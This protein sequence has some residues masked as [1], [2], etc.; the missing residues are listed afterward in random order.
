RDKGARQVTVRVYL[1]NRTKA[2]M[3]AMYKGQPMPALATLTN[4]FKTPP[5]IVEPSQMYDL[6]SLRMDGIVPGKWKRGVSSYSN[7]S[8]YTGQQST[9]IGYLK[10]ANPGLEMK[11]TYIDLPAYGRDPWYS[12]LYNSSS[13]YDFQ[14]GTGYGHA[15]EDRIPLNKVYY[16]LG[17]RG[18]GGSSWETFRNGPFRKTHTRAGASSEGNGTYAPTDYA[19]DP[20]TTAH[21]STSYRPIADQFNH[22]MRY[23]E[24]WEKLNTG[25]PKT[26]RWLLDSMLEKRKRN[27]II[28][29]MHGEVFPM[30][31]MRNYSDPAKVPYDSVTSRV[32]S[33]WGVVPASSDDAKE[34]AKARLVTH[35]HKLEYGLADQVQLRVYPYVSDNREKKPEDDE[36]PSAYRRGIIVLRGVANNL[37]EAVSGEDP[38]HQIQIQVMEFHKKDYKHLLTGDC[39]ERIYRRELV[40]PPSHPAH[41]AGVQGKYIESVTTMTTAA[42]GYQAGDVVIKLKNIPYVHEQYRNQHQAPDCWLNKKDQRYGLRDDTHLYGLHYFPDPALPLLDQHRSDSDKE[43]PRNTARIFVTFKLKQPQ[44]VEVQTTIGGEDDLRKHKLPNLSR[45]WAWVGD[46]APE[47][48]RYQFLGDPRHNPYADV[49]ADKRYNRHFAQLTTDAYDVS[50][51]ASWNRFDDTTNGWGGD[52]TA[53]RHEAD[54][55]AYLGL[56]R[57]ALMR[58]NSMFAQGTGNGFNIIALGGEYGGDTWQAR[59][60]HSSKPFDGKT[61]LKDF[62]TWKRP[63][64]VVDEDNDDDKWFSIPWLGE[65]WPMENWEDWRDTGNLPSKDFRHREWKDVKGY[66]G[67]IPDYDHSRYVDHWGPLGFF[68]ADTDFGYKEDWRI[69]EPTS[70]NG[71][72]LDANLNAKLNP[73]LDVLYGYSLNE[74]VSSRPPDDDRF[75]RAKLQPG[76]KHGSPEYYKSSDGRAAIMPFLLRGSGAD[77]AYYL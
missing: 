27:V 1:S 23:V 11:R 49:R 4:I 42:N 45:T 50:S 48:E 18:G 20:L 71:K 34:G 12:P 58:S 40:W 13:T 74:S 5:V 41:K 51:G 36:P 47:S 44:R 10:G 22:A 76:L 52:K 7:P 6:Y 57:E 14:D 19:V 25:S 8:W 43:D 38:E 32:A 60:D 16:L 56:W 29:N 73:G 75:T 64:V 77:V 37:V 55:P 9:A 68:Y 31:P 24:E 70:D 15:D 66:D 54:V 33:N 26:L 39:D 46:P 2:A 63:T 17:N 28:S 35:P 61:D 3:R 67:H 30:I 72:A 65:I 21:T 62:D 53:G 59:V 69:A